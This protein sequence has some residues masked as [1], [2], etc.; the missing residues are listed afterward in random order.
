MRAAIYTSRTPGSTTVSPYVCRSANRKQN[1]VT[2][3]GPG[4]GFAPRRPRSSNALQLLFHRRTK[5]CIISAAQITPGV[6]NASTLSHENKSQGSARCHRLGGCACRIYVD[7]RRRFE[8]SRRR[9][10]SSRFHPYFSGWHACEPAR[11]QRQVGGALLL[12]E[13]LHERLHH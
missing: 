5:P 6:I 1:C 4:N 13:G 10:G 12:S 8:N 9:R 7:A 11:L 3:N 2:L